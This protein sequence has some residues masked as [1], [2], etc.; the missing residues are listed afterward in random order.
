MTAVNLLQRDDAVI[1][2]EHVLQTEDIVWRH[3]R[4]YLVAALSYDVL[5]VILAQEL[6][7]VAAELLIHDAEAGARGAL[8]L[9]RRQPHA[10]RRI[11]RPF[12]SGYRRPQA[13]K[14]SL[15][16]YPDGQPLAAEVSLYLVRRARHKDIHAQPVRDLVVEAHR[17]LEI[18]WRQQRHDARHD[19]HAAVGLV[20]SHINAGLHLRI[21]HREIP[22]RPCKGL[23]FN[24]LSKS[25]NL[26]YHYH[27]ML[28][29]S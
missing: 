3:S 22:P 15:V 13:Y 18:V 17:V 21:I 7:V 24:F 12:R 4:K 27:A 23:L 26:L 1:A 10:L 8:R 6:H 16:L 25:T 2:V 20:P 19:H 9:L 29:I 28:K 14:P 11:T 5:R